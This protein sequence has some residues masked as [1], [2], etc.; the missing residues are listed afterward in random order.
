M[1]GTLSTQAYLLSNALQK[2]QPVRT[3]H[4]NEGIIPEFTVGITWMP[5]EYYNKND[6]VIEDANGQQY[7][8]ADYAVP[9]PDAE[10]SPANRLGQFPSINEFQ[11]KSEN[12]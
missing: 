12:P 10:V 1:N 8:Y 9:L 6:F 3:S 11:P 4:H 2:M 7:E 5:A